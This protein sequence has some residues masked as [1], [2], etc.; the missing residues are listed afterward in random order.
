MAAQAQQARTAISTH[1]PLAGPDF[2]YRTNNTTTTTTMDP[3]QRFYRHFLET[4]A[5][6]HE[7]YYLGETGE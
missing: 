4:E 3:K 1:H 2:L 6:E 7:H 5:G